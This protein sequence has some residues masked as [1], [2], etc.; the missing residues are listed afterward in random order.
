MT[1]DNNNRGV[2]DPSLIWAVN[3]VAP[4]QPEQE[5][6]VRRQIDQ[7]FPSHSTGDRTARA[8]LKSILFDDP[9]EVELLAA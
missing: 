9:M 7:R 6:S 2:S 1:R 4:I 3:N 8:E 5:E